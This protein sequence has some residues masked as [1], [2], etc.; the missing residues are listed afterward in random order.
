MKKNITHW[1]RSDT[2]YEDSS[3]LLLRFTVAFLMLFHGVHK[4]T[5]GVSFLEGMFLEMGLPGFIA[6]G[7]YLGEVI[8][9]VMLI[10]GCRV[11]IASLLIIMTMIVAVGLA[12]TADIFTLG[13][14]GQWAIEL[15]MFYILASAA[16]LLQGAGRYSVEYYFKRT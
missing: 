9:P 12:H 13:K 4:I 1:L 6:Y 8:A 16:I 15:P 5:H 7:V 11:K 10:I 3:K 14:H 2:Q